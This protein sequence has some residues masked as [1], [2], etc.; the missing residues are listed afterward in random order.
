MSYGFLAVNASGFTQIDGTYDNL[1][2]FASGTANTS[3]DATF[4]GT[5]NNV[6]LPSGTPN[7]FALFAKPST[8]SGNYTFWLQVGSGVFSVM[9]PYGSSSVSYDWKICVRSHDMPSSPD[10]GYGLKVYKS[11]GDEA[12]SSNN[13][14]FKCES[15]T[16]AS[17]SSSGASY[18]PSTMS[19]VYALMNG[20]NE[21]GRFQTDPSGLGLTIVTARRWEYGNNVVKAT[22]TYG[23]RVAP[24]S[25]QSVSS[26]VKT[27]CVGKFV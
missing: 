24:V 15:V 22:S 14:N 4:G 6:S 3:Y 18:S 27:H 25:G 5:T 10:T 16:F 1:A 13:E 23:R 20:C 26:Q 19:G 12:F 17:T 2:V 8:E 21:V 9:S 11:N 7:E